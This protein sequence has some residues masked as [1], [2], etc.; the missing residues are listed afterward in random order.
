MSAN[1]GEQIITHPHIQSCSPPN[2]D[3]GQTD[4][5]PPSTA[6]LP[7]GFI[8][9]CLLESL[10]NIVTLV[11]KRKVCSAVKSDIGSCG[12]FSSV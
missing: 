10:K 6:P 12:L 4:R 11:L 8:Q 9:L 3:Y 2:G 5:E 1:H 7:L